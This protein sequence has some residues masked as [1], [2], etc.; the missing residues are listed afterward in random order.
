MVS[1]LVEMA[2]REKEQE[3]KHAVVRDERGQ[4]QPKDKDLAQQAN[5]SDHGDVGPVDRQ[6]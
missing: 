1:A 3:K 4:D 6:N 5:A 2:I